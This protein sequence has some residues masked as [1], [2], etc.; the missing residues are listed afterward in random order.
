M[1]PRVSFLLPVYNEREH[2]GE[3]LESIAAQD[4]P[5]EQ[6]EVLLAEG[7]STDGTQAIVEAFGRRH[8][9]IALRVI[10]NPGR[11]TAVGRNLGLEAASGELVM[12][13]SGHAVAEPQML[14]VL[15]EKLAAQPAEVAGVG[16]A[17]RS[18]GSATTIGRV[19]SAVLRSRLGG[20]GLDSSFHAP[21]DCDAK[22]IA[23]CLYRREAVEAC[24]RFD[25]K[26]WCG[27]DAELNLRLA[28]AGHRLRFTPDTHVLHYKRPTL[29]G[30]MR[31]MYRY[32]AARAAIT[33]K[34]PGSFR[35]VFLL[36]ALWVLGWLGLTVGSFFSLTVALA[37][38]VSAGLFVIVSAIST[39]AAGESLIGVLLA[40]VVYTIIYTSYGLGFLVGLVIPHSR[41]TSDHESKTK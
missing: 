41:G 34:F 13:F 23:F 37:M 31:Q 1:P 2:L 8:P 10:S 19:I 28:Q 26:F 29:G 24:G 32:G 35:L 6:I 21:A 7:G 3:S 11:N 17:I 36:P 30:L 9:E 25:P 39:I 15:V 20:G 14:R 4:Y 12:N 33:R 38:L 27:Q 22:S 18:S 40:L 16:C 5:A